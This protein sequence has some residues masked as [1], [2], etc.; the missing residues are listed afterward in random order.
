VRAAAISHATHT[1]THTHAHTHTHTHTRTHARTHTHTHT[2]HTITHTQD[3]V[4]YA[5]EGGDYAQLK[6]VDACMAATDA[7]GD[8]AIGLHDYINFAARLK[9][10]WLLSAE[11]SG[12]DGADGGG[13]GGEGGAGGSLMAAAL[14]GVDEGTVQ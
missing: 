12:D 4:L 2:P 10:V 14:A 8:G 13:G 11:A 3:I 5:E 9:A 7:D 6:E 1:R